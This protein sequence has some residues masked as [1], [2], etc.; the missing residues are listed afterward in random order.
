ML[1]ARE[2]CSRQRRQTSSPS[3]RHTDESPTSA[4]LR[5]DPCKFHGTQSITQRPATSA[6]LREPATGPQAW[7][8]IATNLI[9]GADRIITPATQ[10]FMALRS[11]AKTQ[12]IEGASH[13]VSVSRPGPTAAPSG[14]G[15]KP[16]NERRR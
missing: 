13:M 14:P 5:A 16:S 11:G 15:T 4:R 2:P 10:E 3:R 6:A 7:Q 9:G 8:T 12:V 1:R